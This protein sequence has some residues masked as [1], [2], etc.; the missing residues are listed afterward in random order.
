MPS[1]PFD[2]SRVVSTRLNS[3][4]LV[5]FDSNDYSVPDRHAHQRVTLR[6]GIDRIRIECDGQLIAEHRR[7]WGRHQT[8]FPWVHYLG[9]LERKPGALDF[10]RPPRKS[11]NV[12]GLF[13]RRERE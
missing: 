7:A 11:G 12:R 9:V 13:R 4:S 5:R 2:S 3:L 8:I 1:I 6:A 10:A